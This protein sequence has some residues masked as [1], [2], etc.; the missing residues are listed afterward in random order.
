MSHVA[1]VGATA[2]GKS[3]LALALARRDP[4]IELV[5][6]DSM[7]VYRGMDVGTAKPTPAEQAEVPHHLIDLAEPWERFT[8]TR[9]QQHFREARASIEQRGKRPVL[10][11]GTGLY[12][13]AVV[14]DLVIPEEFPRIRTDLEAQTD[15]V[16]LHRRLAA[17]D[18]GAAARMAPTNRR[19]VLRA[20]EVT[21]GSGRPFSSYGPGMETYPETGFRL[22]GVELPANV[23]ADR[24][25]ARFQDQLAQ[26]FVEEVGRLAADPRG[27]SPTARQALGYR[28]LLA[29]V[30]GETSLDAAVELAVL[31]TRRFARR[32]RSW[33]GRDPR[34]EWFRA[35][36]PAEILEPLS[37]VVLAD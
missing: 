23:V 26:G 21:I 17:L 10:V 35:A 36:D 18:P 13:R 19:R 14:D 15:T 37:R 32:Q 28:E 34:I 9:F 30:A 12:L 20:L 2:S 22:L 8:V 11:G 4:S 31:R 27:L 33:F 24:I 3:A 1:L 5:S 7:Q 29:H 25:A 6:V 16:A